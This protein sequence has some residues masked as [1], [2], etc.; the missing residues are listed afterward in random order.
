[1]AETV[2]VIGYVNLVA[3]TALGVVAIRQWRMRRDP[4]AGWAALAFAALGFVVLVARLVPEHPHGFIQDLAQR[5][6]VAVILLFPYL[7]FR[8][9]IAF[10]PPSRRLAR[11]LG[12]MTGLLLVWTFA[13]PRFPSAGEAR[14]WW[15][16]LWLAAFLIHWSVLSI[17]GAARLWRAGIGQPSV[18]RRRMRLLAFASAAITLAIVVSVLQSGTASVAAVVSGVLAF[19]SA[20]SFTLGLAPPAVLRFLWR[21]PEQQRMQHAIEGLMTLATTQ[22]EIAGRVLEPMTAIVGARAIEIRNEEG[23]LLGSHGAAAAGDARVD[24]ALPSGGSLTVWTTPYAPFFGD[25][26]LRLLRT[27]GVLTGVA[28]DRVRLFT[29][30]R[31]TRLALERAN[32][33]KENFVSLA[34]HELRTPVTT[35]HGFVRTLNHVG[36]RLSE[37]QRTELRLELEQQTTRMASL[38]EQLLDLSRLDADRIDIAP[39]PVNVRERIEQLATTAA[40]ERVDEV[41]IEVP[42][43]LVTNVDPTVLDRV[44]GNLIANAMR[45]GAPPVVVTAEQ[46]DSHFRVVVDDHGGGVSPE[47]VPNLFERF[48]RSE[49]S[50]ARSGGTGLGLAIAQSYA[51]AHGGDLRYEGRRPQGARFLLVLPTQPVS[52]PTAAGSGAVAP[53]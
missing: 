44:L 53:R 32:E 37:E 43:E 23:R 20:I 15:F 21:G 9:T 13:L 40:G 6:L 51:R 42:P 12:A 19:V 35:I 1:L 34:A 50:R 41:R 45:Y 18:A 25:E 27:L 22:E 47:F 46:H 8:F 24:I 4:A 36:D 17:V 52:A 29:Q 28:L 7:L 48:T 49:G 10:R 39:E 3:Y 14:P 33:V 38:V 31:E 2:R 16:L 30:E 26:E 11:A 5:V